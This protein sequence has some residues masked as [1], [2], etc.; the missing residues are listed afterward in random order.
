[1]HAR[2]L[3]ARLR[4]DSSDSSVRE[5]GVPA[6]V[7]A[8]VRIPRV[9]SSATVV[10]VKRREVSFIREIPASHNAA[11]VELHPRQVG[12]ALEGSAVALAVR[13]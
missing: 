12:R 3:P 6:P 9:A 5:R 10:Q 1:M 4:V 8:P 11:A 7:G 13:T 2:V